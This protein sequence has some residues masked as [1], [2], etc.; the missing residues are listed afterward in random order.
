MRKH[1][2]TVHGADFYAHKRHKG[3]GDNGHGGGSGGG[4]GGGG[5]GTDDASPYRSD[6]MPM[7]AKTVSVS[8]PS[9]KSEVRIPKM[10]RAGKKTALIC[11]C[12]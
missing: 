1:V 7:S 4:G 12:I 2:K 10:N 6:E 8:S 11:V 5:G 9:I 3:N